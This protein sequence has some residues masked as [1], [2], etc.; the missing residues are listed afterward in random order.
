M[1]V[2]PST[3][4]ETFGIVAG[5]AMGHR[6]P[7]VASD[8]GALAEV[9]DDGVTGLLFEPGN[10]TELAARLSELWEAPERCAAMGEAGRQKIARECSTDAHYAGLHRAYGRALKFGHGGDPVQDARP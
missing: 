9:V 2:V 3:W 1:L 8:I 10:A 7:V 5:E 6:L 4:F